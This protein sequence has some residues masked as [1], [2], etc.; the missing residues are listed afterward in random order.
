MVQYCERGVNLD[1]LEDQMQAAYRTMCIAPDAAS[2]DGFQAAVDRW[3]EAV[4]AAYTGQRVWVVLVPQN[5][6]S[7]VIG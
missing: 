1:A 3:R 6:D 5:V 4:N 2:R 7:E